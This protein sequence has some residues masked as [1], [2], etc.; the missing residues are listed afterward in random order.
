MDIFTEHLEKKMDE[1]KDLVR[2]NKMDEARMKI[3]EIIELDAEIRWN[4]RTCRIITFDVPFSKLKGVIEAIDD[5][6]R[7]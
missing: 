7:P 6:W 5:Q 2:K 4:R 3:G 1:L